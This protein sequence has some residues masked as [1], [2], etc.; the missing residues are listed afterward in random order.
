MVG[1]M[2]AVSLTAWGFLLMI[3]INMDN[4]RAGGFIAFVT[5]V[6]GIASFFA[7]AMWGE[8]IGNALKSIF[9]K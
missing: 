4:Q 3:G 5:G 9:K 6:T 7:F 2:L 1:M 8:K